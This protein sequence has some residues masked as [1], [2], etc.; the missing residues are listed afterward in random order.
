MFQ[1]LCND[2][3]AK[4]SDYRA[5]ELPPPD[6]AH[7]EKWI[8]QFDD[9]KR[10]PILQEMIHIMNRVYL[11][12]DRVINFLQKEVQNPKLTGT[13]AKTFWNNVN[14]LDIQQGGSSQSEMKTLLR[15]VVL[16]QCGVDIYKSGSNNGIYIYLDLVCY[17]G[18]RIKQD[19]Y[20]WL[21]QGRGLTINKIIVLTMFNHT[22]GE[23]YA[24]TKIKKEMQTLHLN[25][26]IEWW[27]YHSFKNALSR[28][29]ESDL[30]MPVSLPPDPYVKKYTEYLESAGHPPKKNLRKPLHNETP[31]I[32]SSEASR[33]LIEQEFLVKGSYIRDIC[34]SLPEVIRPLG[35]SL[36]YTLGFGSPIVSYNNCPN[37]APL[38]LWV[39][40]PWYP[41][42]PRRAN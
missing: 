14:V 27:R 7:V 3:A 39:N 23:W 10:I 19:I 41:L 37:T 8:Y 32:F 13:D 36:M 11:S 25:F 12:K 33:N 22:N 15:S 1:Q 18:N 35:F 24:E 26:E 4:I 31:A 29:N 6:A 42:F 38:V 34:D 5:G 2:L 28:P 40:D 20:S 9:Q 17:S 30:F 21:S 16:Q